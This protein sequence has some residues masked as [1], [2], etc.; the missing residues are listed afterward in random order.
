M[1][2]QTQRDGARLQWLVDHH[3]RSMVESTCARVEEAHAQ[4]LAVTGDP[5]YLRYIMIGATTPLTMASTRDIVSSNRLV[6][7]HVKGGN[8]EWQNNLIPGLQHPEGPAEGSGSS[9]RVMLESACSDSHG[10]EFGREHL[11]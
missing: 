2:Q 6:T 7:Y 11:G 10:S 8:T 3:V 9:L 1:F 4:G 5:K